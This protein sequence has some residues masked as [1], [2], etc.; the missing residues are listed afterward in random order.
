[1]FWFW[2]LLGW[3]GGLVLGCDLGWV[4]RIVLGVGGLVLFCFEFGF[5]G[6]FVCWCV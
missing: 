5:V 4:V 2:V 1:M 6:W 3:F